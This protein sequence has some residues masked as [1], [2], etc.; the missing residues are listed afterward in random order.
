MLVR[1]M[2]AAAALAVFAGG[3]SA[4]ELGIEAPP[5]TGVE[6]I[7][8]EPITIGDSDEDRVYVVE[9]WATWCGPCR[10]SIPH[11]TELQKQYA[12]DNVVIIGISD[13]APEVVAQFA[14]AQGETMQYHVAVAPERG[15]H[16]A[17]MEAF[18]QGGIPTAFI[19]NREGRIA[20]V[21]H[22]MNMDGPLAAIV[23]GTHDIE[24]A[25]LEMA[26]MGA[27]EAAVQ[28]AFRGDMEALHTDAK[29]ILENYIEVPQA[30][31]ELAWLILNIEDAGEENLALAGE[32]AETAFN[33]MDEP[34]AIA[35]LVHAVAL[36]EHGK[37]DEAIAVMKAGLEKGSD[38]PRLTEVMQA[39]LAAW[40]SGEP[41]LIQ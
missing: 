36:G 34:T 14:E 41:I 29:A 19:V 17:Y 31:L 26:A 24:R 18:G 15:P 35:H 20:W 11:L 40:E 28:R 5:L 39:Y 1:M 23:E 4:R 16:Q 9:F 2:A 25:K 37:T 38:N 32:M 7:L 3:A 30:V 13:E 10:Q 27:V 33:A 8:G 6:W 12:D 21:G 22:P